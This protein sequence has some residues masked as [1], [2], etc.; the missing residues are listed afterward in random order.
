LIISCDGIAQTGPR[1]WAVSVM[2]WQLPTPL[3]TCGSISTRLYSLCFSRFLKLY[4]YIFP[5]QNTAFATRRIL[6]RRVFGLVNFWSLENKYKVSQWVSLL[7]HKKTNLKTMLQTV[8][9]I[10]TFLVGSL[11]LGRRLLKWT[12]FLPFLCWKVLW[13]L[14]TLWIPT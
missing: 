7:I 3:S 1:L 4:W 9:R 11:R 14:P 2:C 8:L 13:I 10:R 6:D 12:Y 5:L